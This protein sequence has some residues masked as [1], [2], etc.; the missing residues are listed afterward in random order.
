M[1]R[2]L[3]GEAGSAGHL[4]VM[5][6]LSLMDIIIGMPAHDGQLSLF[7]LLKRTA[8]V[9]THVESQHP[10]QSLIYRGRERCC[11]TD[12]SPFGGH[13]GIIGFASAIEQVL[14]RSVTGSVR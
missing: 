1:S 14:Y 12:K 2:R 3:D 11:P 7:R 8:V 4:Q 10:C 13:C 5:K 6:I 9:F